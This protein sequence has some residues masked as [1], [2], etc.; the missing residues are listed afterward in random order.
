MRLVDDRHLIVLLNNTGGTK[1][2]E[3]S[4]SITGILYGK[5]YDLPKASEAVQPAK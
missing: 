3:M 5:N 1:L 2:G 4:R